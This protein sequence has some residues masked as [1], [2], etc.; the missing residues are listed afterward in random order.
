MFSSVFVI[1]AFL[2]SLG[3]SGIL[4]AALITYIRRTWQLMRSEGDGSIQHRILDGVDQL[5]ARMDF[6]Q[7][8]MERMEQALQENDDPSRLPSGGRENPNQG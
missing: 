6:L 4:A 1:L 2:L 8:R 5:H 7:E 3:F